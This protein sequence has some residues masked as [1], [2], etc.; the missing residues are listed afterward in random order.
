M[1]DVPLASED[2]RA[3]TAM[4]EEAP[5]PPPRSRTVARICLTALV[6]CL[7]AALILG[8]TCKNSDICR[9]GG[10]DSAL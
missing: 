9:L 4:A 8:G 10:K 2:G 1:E 5:P 3:K 7:S 6:L